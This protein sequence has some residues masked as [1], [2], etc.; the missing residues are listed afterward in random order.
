MLRGP[1][2][3]ERTCLRAA[4][5]KARADCSSTALDVPRT[6]PSGAA[7][8]TCFQSGSRRF[9]R[10]S[11]ALQ[12]KPNRDEAVFRSATPNPPIDFIPILTTVPTITHQVCDDKITFYGVV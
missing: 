4:L 12:A 10:P 1:D 6:H 2:A 7:F 8:V 3:P 5:Y 11:W 9:R